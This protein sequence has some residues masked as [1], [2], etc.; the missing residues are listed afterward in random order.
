TGWY[1]MGREDEKGALAA[2][3]PLLTGLGADQTS[4][5]TDFLFRSDHGGFNVLGV[6]NLMLWNSMDRYETLVHQASDTFDS[7]VRSDL[8]QT[9]AVTGSTA[10]AM[11]DAPQPFVARLSHAEVADM[12]RKCNAAADFNSAR[13]LSCLKQ[14]I[15]LKRKLSARVNPQT[16]ASIVRS[17]FA[18]SSIGAEALHPHTAA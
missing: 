17:T 11:A 6:P 9:V 4:S 10:Y 18:E 7:V 12:F 16:T 1:V 3:E 13:V 14:G 8:G 15:K 5:D 2:I